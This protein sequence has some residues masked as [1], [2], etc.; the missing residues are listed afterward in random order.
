MEEKLKE[1]IKNKYIFYKI[2][3]YNCILLLLHGNASI[4]CNMW[5]S[6]IQAN[7]FKN[8]AEQYSINLAIKYN[9]KSDFFDKLYR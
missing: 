8:Q 3:M 2:N 5:D 7:G 4:F 9:I 1:F 6:F